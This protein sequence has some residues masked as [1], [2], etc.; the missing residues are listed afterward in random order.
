M[1]NYER[2]GLISGIRVSRRAP[3]ISS[4]L[5]A[6]DSLLF[7]K[8]DEGQVVQVKEL[9]SVFEKGTGQK[10]SSAKCPLLVR[11]GADEELVNRVKVSLGVEREDFDAK[12]LGLPVPA[13]RMR[14]GVFQ[15]IEERCVKRMVDWK[16]RTLSQVAKEVVQA[17]PI[18]TEVGPAY[19]TVCKKMYI[20]KI[21]CPGTANICDECF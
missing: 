20:H 6:D 8:L 16:E 2:Q 7:F 19:K 3:S 13:G 11:N 15:T 18:R 10:L 9:L 21:S 12:Y 1:K 5:F 14:R 17:L 4:L